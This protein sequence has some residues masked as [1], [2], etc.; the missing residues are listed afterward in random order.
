MPRFAIFFT[1]SG[2]A[3]V[4]ANTEEDARNIADRLKEEDISWTD[5]WELT[6]SLEEEE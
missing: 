5:T 6:D 4:N 1:R 2:V 3:F